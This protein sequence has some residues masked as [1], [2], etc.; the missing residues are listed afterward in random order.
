[1]IEVLFKIPVFINVITFYKP[2]FN[3][4]LLIH[5]NNYINNIQLFI[6]KIS[7]LFNTEIYRYKNA[8]V[9]RVSMVNSSNKKLRK[10]KG[11]GK[12]RVGLRSTPLSRG[13]GIV[14][15][16]L[17][18]KCKINI[19]KKIISNIKGSLLLYKKN[20]IIILKLELIPKFVF[21]LNYLIFK[22]LGI[23]KGSKIL[24][25]YNMNVFFRDFNLNNYSYLNKVSLLNLIIHDYLVFII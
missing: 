15:G 8:S 23:F 3:I 11:L 1:M 5:L 14:F 10:Q 7:T 4:F 13:G 9:K 25:L 2:Y 21:N 12:A 16:P 19:N 17:P 18:M 22:V 24:Y 6:T 20:N